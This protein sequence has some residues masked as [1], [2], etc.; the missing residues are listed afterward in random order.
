MLAQ[1]PIQPGPR[2]Q[3]KPQP[4]SSSSLHGLPKQDKPKTRLE[5]IKTGNKV[6]TSTRI[7]TLN[8][9]AKSSNIPKTP[10][11][12][13][14]ALIIK[15]VTHLPPLP[16]KIKTTPREI[17]L[18][19][20][21]SPAYK[22]VGQ[23][24]KKVS[25]TGN[26]GTK[27][28][29]L[30]LKGS[31]PNEQKDQ[32]KVLPVEPPKRIELESC[33]KQVSIINE[34]PGG[35]R[36]FD[37]AKELYGFADSLLDCHIINFCIH[38]RTSPRFGFVAN[39]IQITY[40]NV[41]TGQTYQTKEGKVDFNPFICSRLILANGEFIKYVEVANGRYLK[42]RTNKGRTDFVGNPGE[43][44]PSV[45]DIG[46]NAVVGAYSS[47]DGISGLGFYIAPKNEVKYYGRRPYILMK[48]WLAK[49]KDV[50]DQL[51]KDRQEGKMKQLSLAA[52]AFFIVATLIDWQTYTYILKYI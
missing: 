7:K 32:E 38:Y 14:C 31:L 43:T 3:P 36:R 20:Q 4:S 49:N 12:L 29:S 21:V 33:I 48:V 35:T 25:F 37:D 39:D 5:E 47:G 16:I 40:K 28:P 13:S 41:V 51:E 15:S 52:Q 34:L 44:T 11:D 10:F 50:R 46:D 42:V 27:L 6:V 24:D 45:F 2:T 19:S 26:K 22:S 8:G 17:R 23:K 1:K 9:D 18:N 30:K